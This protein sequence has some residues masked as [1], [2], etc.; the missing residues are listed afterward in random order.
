MTAAT[1][2]P[3]T[4]STSA[5]RWV[6]GVRGDSPVLLCGN[7]DCPMVWWPDRREPQGS[8]PAP[9]RES[10]RNQDLRELITTRQQNERL[11]A[12]VAE[13]EAQINEWAALGEQVTHAVVTARAVVTAWEEAQWPPPSTEVGA[14]I[15]D[16]TEA[17]EVFQ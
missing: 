14:R 11:T 8:C 16:L 6:R 15:A 12:R 5:H 9:P 1:M 17:L 2:T 3:S 7:G 10:G 4:T 13:L